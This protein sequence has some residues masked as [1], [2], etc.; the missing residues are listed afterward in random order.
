MRASL[1]K[2]RRSCRPAGPG[3]PA[4]Q[5]PLISR[6]RGA[7]YNNTCSCCHVAGPGKKVGGTVEIYF[8][9]GQWNDGVVC[10][11]PNRRIHQSVPSIG[12]PRHPSIGSSS[13]LRTISW[14]F[15][16]VQL[17]TTHAEFS[18]EATV[19]F[20]QEEAL[21]QAVLHFHVCFRHT[22]DE[23]VIRHWP[24]EPQ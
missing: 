18:K 2:V 19:S 11:A 24:P 3:R 13:W 15:Q 1:L 8:T 23:L 14:H 5:N 7:T 6:G 9:S 16:A 21:Q 20:Q 4:R 10:P 22:A 17:P 12:P